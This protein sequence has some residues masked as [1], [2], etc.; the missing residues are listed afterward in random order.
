MIV[1]MEDVYFSY[2]EKAILEDLTL[3]IAAREFVSLVGTSGCG[4]STVFRLLLGLEQPQQGHIMKPERIGYM[5]QQH[6]LMPWRTALDNAIVPLECQGVAKKV[7][8]ERA[9]QLFTRFGLV[10]YET[11]K[12]HELSGGMQQRVS[13]IR[14]LLTGADVLLLDEPFSALDALTR[15]DLQH[16]LKEVV[17]AEHKM[18]LFITHDIEEALSLS[19]RILIATTRPITTFEEVDATA[20]KEQIYAKIGGQRQ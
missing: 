10:G 8:R 6:Q 2:G 12:P 16:W 17:T 9:Q 11:K 18:V 20:N 4:K 15:T 5:P 3:H 7:A 1:A 14:T 19:E 13:F